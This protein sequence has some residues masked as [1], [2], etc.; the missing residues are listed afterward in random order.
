MQLESY[1]IIF[2]TVGLIGILL[3]SSPSIGLLVKAPAGE[4]F[5]ELYILGPNHMTG[6]F[7][8]NITENVA[9]TVYLGVGNYMGSSAYYTC[10]VKLRNTSEPLPNATL[11][12]P[13]PLPALYEFKTFLKD[14]QTWETPLTFKVNSVSF[15][16]N[17]FLLQSI[18]I[19]DKEFAVNKTAAWNA[20]S[21]GYYYDLL[22]E[23]WAYNASMGAV[24]YN[25]RFVQLYVNVTGNI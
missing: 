21:S 19:N 12:T 20:E 23:L 25:N 22:I 17:A 6:N 13:S 8:F 11:G 1:R 18:T 16:S 3:F 24:Q 10:Y 4:E 14:G 7:P 2:V 15:S 9:Y 5:S